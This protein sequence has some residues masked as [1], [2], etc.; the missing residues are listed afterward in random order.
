MTCAANSDQGHFSAASEQLQTLHVQMRL[1]PEH[2]CSRIINSRLQCEASMQGVVRHLQF[3]AARLL[4]IRMH[5]HVSE[6][7]SLE[8]AVRLL[9]SPFS[10]RAECLQLWALWARQRVR[11][12]CRATQRSAGVDVKRAIVLSCYGS[13]HTYSSPS[14]HGNQHRFD[15]IS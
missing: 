4:E 14:I 6:Q 11:Q 12:L 15:I 13:V 2:C 1:L 5:G 9:S 7:K 8:L 3:L 10:S